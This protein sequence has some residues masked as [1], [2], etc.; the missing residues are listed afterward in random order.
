MNTFKIGDTVRLKTDSSEYGHFREA[1]CRKVQENRAGCEG[2][3]AVPGMEIM[4]I[5]GLSD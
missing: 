2:G 5:N 3:Y 1:G 4:T